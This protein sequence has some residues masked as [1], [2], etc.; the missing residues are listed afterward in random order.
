M[1]LGKGRIAIIA[2]YADLKR[3]S[4]ASASAGRSTTRSGRRSRPTSIWVSSPNF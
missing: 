1:T 2:P 3:E 4:E